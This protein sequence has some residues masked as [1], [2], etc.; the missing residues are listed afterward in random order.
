MSE[1]LDELINIIKKREIINTRK[2]VW[3]NL[4]LVMDFSRMEE[5]YNW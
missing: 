4:F 5:Y 3:D 1:L 2:E